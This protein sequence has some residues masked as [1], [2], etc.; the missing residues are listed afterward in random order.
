M[1][2]R[3]IW[4][5]LDLR[6]NKILNAKTDEPI[7]PEHISTK[8]YVDG[9]FK[10]DTPLSN[11]YKNPFM[12][13]WMKNIFNKSYN[14]VFD[15]L[16]YPRVLPEYFNPVF[17]NITDIN[18]L[19]EYPLVGTQYH[20]GKPMMLSSMNYNCVIKISHDANDRVASEQST[21]RI[22]Y[23]NKTVKEFKSVSTNN[24]VS[25]F[26]IN[27]QYSANCKYE[28]IMKFNPTIQTKKDSYDNDYVPD[29]FKIPYILT[30]DITDIFNE[31]II[32]ENCVL[33]NPKEQS[34][35]NPIPEKTTLTNLINPTLGGFVQTLFCERQ[36]NNERYFATVLIP[37]SI[38]TNNEIFL[39]SVKIGSMFGAIEK[40]YIE[41][42]NLIDIG[43]ADN[44][45]TLPTVVVDD[46]VNKNLGIKY[47]I[48][49]LDMGYGKN[50]KHYRL[51]FKNIIKN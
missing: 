30:K 7:E 20:N 6:N 42:T 50:N 22:T 1:N 33:I 31:K 39:L 38:F 10:Y 2:I 27:F 15:E 28:F 19:D 46:T 25:T 14:D 40:I 23:F 43:E 4:H 48:C 44:I 35:I 17:G 13:K 41:K 18:I 45:A 37:L 24:E 3:K 51:M 11:K 9:K 49:N 12:F 36:N 32:P 8:R 34:A 47:V 26:N 21:L 16:L 5:S 29:D